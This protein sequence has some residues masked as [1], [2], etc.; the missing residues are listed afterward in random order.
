MQAFSQRPSEEHIR[1]KLKDSRLLINSAMASSKF[2]FIIAV[3]TVF[4]IPLSLA[5]EFVVGDQK[6]WSLDFDYQG[7]AA[8]KE[9]RVGDKLGKVTLS[10]LSKKYIHVNLQ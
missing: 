1:R 9:F 4:A 2:I 5:T 3:V 10:L 6:G 7:W 8:G